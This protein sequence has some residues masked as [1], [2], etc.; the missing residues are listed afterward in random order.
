MDSRYLL[1]EMNLP[2]SLWQPYETIYTPSS[3]PFDYFDG[4]NSS[5]TL[6]SRPT[7]HRT[8]LTQMK[9]LKKGLVHEN[10]LT[11]NIS[12]LGELKPS[13]PWKPAIKG[14]AKKFSGILGKRIPEYRKISRENLQ[15]AMDEIDFE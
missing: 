9:S 15:K 2:Y 10:S 3:G 8:K 4:L 11:D 13:K 6:P 14:A 7:L 5:F 12:F 1:I